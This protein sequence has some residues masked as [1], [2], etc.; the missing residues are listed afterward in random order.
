MGY[1]FSQENP[2]MLKLYLE[3]RDIYN[4]RNA[5]DRQLLRHCPASPW[6]P[7]SLFG[8]PPCPRGVPGV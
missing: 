4:N 7:Q 3:G 5:A 1:T 6:S 8:M 2:Q